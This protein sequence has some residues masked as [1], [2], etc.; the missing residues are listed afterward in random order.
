M[1]DVEEED[2]CPDCGQPIDPLTLRCGPN[3]VWQQHMDELDAMVT[4]RAEEG[5]RNGQVP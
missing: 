2:R 5:R 4:K 1:D 3:C